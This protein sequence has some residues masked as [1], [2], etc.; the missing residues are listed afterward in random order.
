MVEVVSESRALPTELVQDPPCRRFAI[1]DG[2]IL[3]AG[4]ALW[5]AIGRTL[6]LQFAGEFQKPVEGG[7]SGT[8][9]RFFAVPGTFVFWSVIVLTPLFLI[10]RLRRPRP[11]LRR[12]IW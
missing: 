4:A 11:E 8:W 3:I 10:I 5:L 7:W 1:L 2:M 6:V 12:L 9:R